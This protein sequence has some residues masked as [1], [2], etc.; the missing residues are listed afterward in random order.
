[1]RIDVHNHAIPERV[2]DLLRSEPAYRTRIDD[3]WFRRGAA[4]FRIAASFRDPHEKLVELEAKGLDAAVVSAAPPLFL[5]DVDA[6]AGEALCR[7][8]NEGLREFAATHPDRYRWMAHVPLAAPGRAAGV[9]EEA[10]AAGAVG[11]EVGTSIAG[12][13]LDEEDFE[14][15]WAAAETLGM[16]VMLHPAYNEANRGLDPFY[17]QNVIGNLLETTIAGERLI[18]AGV[19]DR[20]PALRVL[21]VHGGGYYPYQA[22]RLRHAATVRTELE[23]AP[24]DPW[25]YRG[26]V[27]VDTITHDVESLRFLLH[28][29][30]AENVVMGTDLPFD[31]AT[32]EPVADL[33]AAADAAT[34][35]A[36]AEHNPARLFGFDG[37]PPR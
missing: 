4:S 11:V 2:L 26:Q 18:C 9:L 24:R 1:M 15:F 5:Y 21:L 32:P 35:R 6:E 14:P 7:A 33:E 31:M 19:L 17:L 12:R 27:L 10:V 30:G 8:T 22:G 28:R 3:G 34:A 25:A 20:H 16:P 23:S 29:M 36:V 37:D 13:R